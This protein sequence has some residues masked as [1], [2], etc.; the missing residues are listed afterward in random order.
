M[1]NLK[2]LFLE[3]LPSLFF[4]LKRDVSNDDADKKFHYEPVEGQ[5]KPFLL[6][7]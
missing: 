5:Q 2:V 7:R 6:S 1:V 3:S 4:P